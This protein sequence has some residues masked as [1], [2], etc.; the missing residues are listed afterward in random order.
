MTLAVTLVW[1][2]GKEDSD[3]CTNHVT[4]SPTDVPCDTVAVV[5][6]FCFSGE[7]GGG[8]EVC[9]GVGFG[10]IVSAGYETRCYS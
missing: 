4:V 7:G 8:P 10:F 1:R 6:S 2:E 9:S 5:A 3:T